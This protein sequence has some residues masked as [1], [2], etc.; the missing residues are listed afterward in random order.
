MDQFTQ[1]YEKY[2]HLIPKVVRGCRIYKEFD[3]YEQV[4]AE[5]LWHAFEN[6]TGDMEEFEPYAYVYMKND[7]RNE[8]R[9]KIGH[10]EKNVLMDNHESIQIVGSNCST[11]DLSDTIQKLLQPLNE[12]ER[13]MLI[14]LYA[15]R[16]KY[17]EVA[18]ELGI[19][20]SALKKR[21]DRL[22][23]KLRSKKKEIFNH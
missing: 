13:K 18:K 4:A 5:A 6:Y 11:P 20:T 16:Q 2:K 22:V 9:K 21:R 1:I 23:Q 15:E 17:E 19:S 8:L 10:E 7:V 14:A 12:T 3:H